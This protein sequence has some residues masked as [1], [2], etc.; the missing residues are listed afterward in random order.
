[1]P[2][3]RK[4]SAQRLEACPHAGSFAMGKEKEFFSGGHGEL[5]LQ[6][7]LL[8]VAAC[9]ARAS[10]AG[11]PRRFGTS[12][13]AHCRT[14]LKPGCCAPV[15][16]AV[17]SSAASIPWEERGWEQLSA[18]G[19]PGGSVAPPPPFRWSLSCGWLGSSAGWCCRRTHHQQAGDNHSHG[20]NRHSRPCPKSPAAALP[21][22]IFVAVPSAVQGALV[23]Q[24]PLATK[25][26][27]IQMR[28]KDISTK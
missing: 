12:A 4:H 14:A 17:V 2:T 9:P 5:Q 10:S 19:Q 23:F 28:P 24:L 18:A 16:I 27:T 26:G 21:T 11:A 8:V 20:S 25:N 7:K 15:E 1:M 3:S 6:I 13:T 22:S